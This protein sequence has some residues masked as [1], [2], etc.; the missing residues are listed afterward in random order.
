[1][2]KFVTSA[3]A[4]AALAVIAAPD[5]SAFGRRKAASC[6]RTC[7]VEPV[8]CSTTCVPN[9]CCG[10]IS[11]SAISSS[12]FASTTPGPVPGGTGATSTGQAGGQTTPPPAFNGKIHT[13]LAVATDDASLGAMVTKDL[14]LMQ[15]LVGKLY[16]MLGVT[17]PLDE[18]PNYHE[19][20]GAHFTPADIERAIDGIEVGSEDR[21]FLYIS[22]HGAT[23][24][25]SG[26][27]TLTFGDEFVPRSEFVNR[28]KAKNAKLAVLLTDA[29]AVEL[30]L[31]LEVKPVATE[32]T[33]LRSLLLDN[34]GFV[35]IN[36]CSRGEASIA[37]PTGS[38]MTQAFV[39]LA[40][41]PVAVSTLDTSN[42]DKI[43]WR[44]EFF[45]ALV[46][47]T[48]KGYEELAGKTADKSGTAFESQPGQHPF[49]YA[50]LP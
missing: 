48:N 50:E 28:L 47:E 20:T 4:L 27:H 11:V 44:T 26:V 38:L 7:C 37:T 10:K 39:K 5:A 22:S 18:T 17:T 19:L 43:N 41:V 29:C 46:A 30:P 13:I 49:A 21:I 15:S 40:D 25:D 42:D 24:K 35:D 1:M 34:V 45:P 2:P 23:D 36:A 9:S 14:V 3:L 6:V 32:K 16:K 12:A 8:A 31:G 33:L